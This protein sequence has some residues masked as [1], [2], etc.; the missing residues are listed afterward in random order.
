MTRMRN[1]RR[2]FVA[3]LPAA[4]VPG[5]AHAAPDLPPDDEACAAAP[6][7]DALR[8]ALED[9]ADGR[10]LP[11]PLIALTRCPVCGCGMSSAAAHPAIRPTGR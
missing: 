8:A 4:L 2:Q 10:P 3:C 9:H 1:A 5:F 7:H 11:A 6:L